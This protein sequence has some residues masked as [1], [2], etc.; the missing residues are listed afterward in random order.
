MVLIFETNLH[1]YEKW[2]QAC[3]SYLNFF[4]HLLIM[5]KKMKFMGLWEIGYNLNKFKIVFARDESM[6][7]MRHTSMSLF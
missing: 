7:N 1:I 4:L 5:I 6:Q 3:K 2:I